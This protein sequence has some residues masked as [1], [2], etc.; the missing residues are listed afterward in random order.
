MVAR[1]FIEADLDSQTFSL[2]DNGFQLLQALA[3]LKEEFRYF[4]L[5]DKDRDE[6]DAARLDEAHAWIIEFFT[7]A[8]GIADR[9]ESRENA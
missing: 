4:A 3:P 6:V 5:V 7:K 8:K 1:G 9:T 2:T